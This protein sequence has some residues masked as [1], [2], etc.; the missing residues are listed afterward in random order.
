M[1]PKR[2]GWYIPFCI[3]AM[4]TRLE[5]DENKNRTNRSKHGIRFEA[6]ALVFEDP[7][8]ITRQDRDVEGNY[9]GKR[10]AMRKAF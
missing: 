1:Y 8:L 10:S 6:A 3:Y 7:N 9:A 5:W 2:F 4:A